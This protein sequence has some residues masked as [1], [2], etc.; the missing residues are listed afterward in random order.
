MI[1]IS[2]HLEVVVLALALV[3]VILGAAFIYQGIEKETWM[4]EVMQLEKVT[5]VLPENVVKAGEVIDSPEEE[6]AIASTIGEHR[7]TIASSYQELLGEGC[8]DSA[9]PQLLTYA[10]ALNMENYLHL[11]VFGFGLT[12]VVV[13][14]GAFMVMVGISLCSIGAALLKLTRGIY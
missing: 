11:A 12:T 6:Q 3:S 14:V 4:W 5:F 8:F 13:A 7:R 9:N 10:Q 2:Q 1:H